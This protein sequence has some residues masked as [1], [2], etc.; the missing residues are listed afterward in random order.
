MMQVGMDR[1]H[2]FENRLFRYENDDKKTKNETI[3]F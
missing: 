1:F 2:F 3:G